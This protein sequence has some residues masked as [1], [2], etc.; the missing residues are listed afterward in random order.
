MIAW[1]INLAGAYIRQYLE[2]AKVNQ[3]T[4]E[5]LS[6]VIEEALRQHQVKKEEAASIGSQTHEYAEKFGMS[7]LNGQDLPEID[8]DSDE[9]VKNGIDAFLQ[10]FNAHNVKF[11]A[12]ERMLYSEENGY[13][14]LT[15]A[16]AIVDG[17]NTLIDYKTSKGI[18]S[19]YR[20]Q[21][22]AYCA[23]YEE[24]T[25]DKLDQALIAH[26]NKDTGEF[27]TLVL[28]REDIEK[29]FKVFLACL[30]VK[31]REKELSKYY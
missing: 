1:A 20:Y 11:K 5:E 16:I 7:I 3:F 8:P 25:G 14:G 17:K 21:I 10:W 18:Y 30:E 29:D 15:D 24:E 31:K 27:D 2:N 23:A 26:F 22:A 12:T 19:E 13:V 9:K 4:S 28:T 6:P